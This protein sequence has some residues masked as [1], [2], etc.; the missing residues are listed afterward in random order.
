MP[1]TVVEWT[2]EDAF[3]KFGFDDG[4][5]WNGTN[6][7]SD[8]I[9]KLGYETECDG[10]GCHNYLVM[11]IKKDGKSI[12]FDDYRGSWNAA[13]VARMNKNGVT[14]ISEQYIGYTDPHL[15]LPDDILEML[16]ATFT[17]D[18]EVAA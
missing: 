7:V 17:D 4:D 5:G 8:A 14:N 18:Y 12:L 1:R 10:W 16:N 9:E 15:F 6:L 2:W 13:T 11:D 3:S